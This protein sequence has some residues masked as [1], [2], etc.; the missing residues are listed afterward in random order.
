MFTK[1]EIQEAQSKSKGGKDF[2][3]LVQ[4][5]KTMGILLYEHWV[6]NGENIYFG[7]NNYTVKI[8][9]AQA[10]LNVNDH[11]SEEKLKL[12]LKI[13]QAGQTDYPTFCLQSAE[14]GV[15]KWVTDMN[16]LTVAYLD[17]KGNTLVL[18][19]IPTP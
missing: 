5:F 2:P 16:K 8:E 19:N 4:D 11:S 18:E 6:G 10:L 1:E 13:H 17:K 14:A 9:S 7:A 3:Q 15:E 12:A